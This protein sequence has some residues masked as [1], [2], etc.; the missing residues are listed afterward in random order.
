MLR[1]CAFAALVYVCGASC[2][3]NLASPKWIACR[4][5]SLSPADLV[6]FQNDITFGDD[7]STLPSACLRMKVPG[8]ILTGLLSNNTFAGLGVANDDSLWFESNLNLLP[9]IA[10]VGKK[11]YTYWYRTTL[12]PNPP[13]CPSQSSR[14]RLALDGINYR[15]RVVVNG[16]IVADTTDVA[17]MFKRHHLP[18]VPQQKQ[19]SGTNKSATATEAR[20]SATYASV[21]AILVLP[22]D[23]PG[24]GLHG[25]QGGDHQIARN[26]ASS[27]YAAGW[28]WCSAET[29]IQC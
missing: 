23:F 4:A 15:A 8:T 5:D 13:N 24:S 12:P 11:Y 21:L 1:W 10:N 26:A 6:V 3:V 20:A 2:S 27:Q 25:G 28:D 29:I 7:P 14:R 9:D 17:G 16:D 19:Y 18:L 22:L